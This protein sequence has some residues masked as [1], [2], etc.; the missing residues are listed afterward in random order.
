MIGGG[1]WG[2]VQDA[3]QD[4]AEEVRRRQR[5]DDRLRGVPA[6]LQGQVGQGSALTHIIRARPP[7]S[8]SEATQ[9]VGIFGVRTKDTVDVKSM[10]SVRLPFSFPVPRRRQ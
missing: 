7:L 2:G 4:G 6:A 1:E 8:R 9:C 3:D 10:D 5:R